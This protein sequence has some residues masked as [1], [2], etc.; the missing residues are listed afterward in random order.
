MRTPDQATRARDTAT[1]TRDG[2]PRA[3]KRFGQHFLEPV[4]AEKV[5]AAIAPSPTDT[6]IEIGP[7]PGVMTRMLH[8]SAARVVAYEIDRDMVEHLHRLDLPRVAIR[9]GDFLDV[10]GDQIRADL[11]GAGHGLGLARV[12]GN[13]PYNA[14]SPILVRLVDLAAAGAPLR[15]ASVMLQ[16]EVA[17]R[18]LASPGSK[19]YGVLTVVVTHGAQVERLLQLPAGAF[20]PVPKVQSTLVRLTFHPP[21]PGVTDLAAFRAMTQALF[22]RRRKTLL[23]A[24]RAYPPALARGANGVLAHLGLDPVRR[25]ET[26]SVAEL[27]ALSNL[28]AGSTFD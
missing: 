13:L 18:L 2:A 28:L 21:A 4:W 27:A 5:I 9:E 3:R 25:P 24:L 16:R 12:A 19:D 23:N 14:A 1:R 22:S 20:R 10:T 26:L 7:G 17:D 8:T 6:F 11:S 15:D